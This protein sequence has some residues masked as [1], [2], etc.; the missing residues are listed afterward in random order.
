MAKSVERFATN[1]R[2]GLESAWQP[3]YDTA[4][5]DIDEV[6]DDTAESSA[7]VVVVVVVV[8]VV[9]LVASPV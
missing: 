3:G 2:R 7:C 5:V 9:S 4:A 8:V 6:N 1:F